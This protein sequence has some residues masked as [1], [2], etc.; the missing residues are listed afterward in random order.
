LK[1]V[2]YKVN[3]QDEPIYFLRILL[4]RNTKFFIKFGYGVVESSLRCYSNFIFRL[5]NI[6]IL[7]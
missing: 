1:K 4:Y 2:K 5:F 3:I 7:W 6:F